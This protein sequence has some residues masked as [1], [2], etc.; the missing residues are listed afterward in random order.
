MK[1]RKILIIGEQGAG[2]TRLAELLSATY[3]LPITEGIRCMSEIDD[4]ADGIYTSNCISE[5][6]AEGYL[7]EYAQGYL[8]RIL[9]LIHIR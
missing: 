3:N 4:T 7:D 1:T 5:A 2:K 8:K 6:H 9:T